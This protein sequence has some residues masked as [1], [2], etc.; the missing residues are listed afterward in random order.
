M[1]EMEFDDFR[2]SPSEVVVASHETSQLVTQ[3]GRVVVALGFAQDVNFPDPPDGDV[4]SAAHESSV[5]APFDSAG[6][7]RD[8]FAR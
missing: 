3:D 8:S 4:D 7:E 6:V 2:S 5:S 1:S